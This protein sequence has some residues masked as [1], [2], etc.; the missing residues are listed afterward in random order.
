MFQ[1]ISAM[2]NQLSI[3]ALLHLKGQLRSWELDQSADQS[4]QN[5]PANQKGGKALISSSGRVVCDRDQTNWRKLDFST[6]VWIF[7]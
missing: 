4:P 3:D 7:G 6:K 5:L 1:D 2:Q